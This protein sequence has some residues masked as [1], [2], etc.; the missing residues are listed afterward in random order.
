KIH[1]TCG[2]NR[3]VGSVFT[4]DLSARLPSFHPGM[5]VEMMAMLLVSVIQGQVVFLVFLQLFIPTV[6][7]VACVPS[8]LPAF[9]AMCILMG[10]SVATMFLPPW[11]MLPDVIDY[12]ASRQASFKD[13]DP[14]FFSGCAFCNKLA[15]G[16]SVGLSTMTLQIE[17][18]KAGACN[19]GDEV[20]TA[21]IVLGKPFKFKIGHQEV[22]RGWEEGVA[23]VRRTPEPPIKAVMIGINTPG[24][25][26]VGSIRCIVIECFRYITRMCLTRYEKQLLVMCPCY[27]QM[28]VGQRAKLICS[29][30]FAYG[31]KGHPGIIPPNATL[32]FDVELLGLEA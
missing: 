21:L 4:A 2:F 12:F 17:G 5:S 14:L 15:G 7:T 26:L 18:Y 30:D 13:L 23:Q 8:N 10:F 3:D 19:H 25:C 6:I 22:I 9:M 11:S 16:L 1:I 20:V 24:G 31:S 32:T 27:P 28:S 29:P